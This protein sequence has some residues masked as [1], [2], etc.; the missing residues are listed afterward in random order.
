MTVQEYL[1]DHPEA[2]T[3]ISKINSIFESYG[4]SV[5]EVIK[6]AQILRYKLF[7][8]LDIK[9]QDKIRKAQKA[10]EFTLTSALNSNDIIYGKSENYLYIEKKCSFIPIDSMKLLNNRPEKGLM[11]LLGQDIDGKPC[12]TDLRKAP[13]MLVAGTTGSGKS[14]LLHTFIASLLVKRRTNPCWLYIIDP[15]RSEYSM[16]KNRN[17]VTLITETEK[18]IST[19]AKCCDI[20]ESRYKM[21]ED[22]HIKDI[23]QLNDDNVYPIVI[24]VDELRDLLM[25]DKSAEYYL[26][27]LAQKARACGIHLILGTQTPRA[28]VL[29]GALRANIPTRIALK[30]STAIESRIIIERNGADKLF[31]LGD[32][33]YLG[34]EAFNPIRIQAAYTNNEQKN[35]IASALIYEAPAEPTQQQKTYIQEPPKPKKVGLIGGLI[36]LMKVKPIMFVSENNPPEI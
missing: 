33:L 26:V 24:I 22:K 9:A 34:N 14:E 12:Y 31:G 29:T 19:L 13:H 21:L 28:D 32:M 16:Y 11:L 2:L 1:H 15:K 4:I 10:I 6:S 7:L 20:M 5:N 27:R 8:P 23:S 30:T 3:E 18:A 35:K 17:G 25:Q 36:N